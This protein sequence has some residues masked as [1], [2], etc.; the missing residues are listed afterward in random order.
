[1][2][3]SFNEEELLL[4]LLPSREKDWKSTDKGLGEEQS[5]CC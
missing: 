1:M 2:R 5:G 3:C 4:M